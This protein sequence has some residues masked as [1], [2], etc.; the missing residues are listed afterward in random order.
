MLAQLLFRRTPPLPF[1]CFSIKENIS[2]RVVS[3]F[4]SPPSSLMI[5]PSTETLSNLW[6]RRVCSPIGFSILPSPE[7]NHLA[8]L[9]QTAEIF[10]G[11]L[12]LVLTTNFFLA[13]NLPEVAGMVTRPTNS[14]RVAVEEGKRLPARVFFKLPWLFIHPS[15]VVWSISPGR[16]AWRKSDAWNSIYHPG[17]CGKAVLIMSCSLCKIDFA[18]G[19]NH[20]G[21]ITAGNDLESI[22]H[23]LL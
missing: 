5:G 15:A 16:G 14:K 12:H 23:F 2:V 3:A 18:G 9:T 6:Q 11:A 1:F 22:S 13:T 4:A 21:F 10:T 17:S 19:S 8:K 20:V 7:R